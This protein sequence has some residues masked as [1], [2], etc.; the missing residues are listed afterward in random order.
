MRRRRGG[1]GGEDAQPSLLFGGGDARGGQS[2]PGCRREWHLRRASQSSRP[3]KAAV[4][5][6]NAGQ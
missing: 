1:G 2:I 4:I 5:V 6:L 3:A